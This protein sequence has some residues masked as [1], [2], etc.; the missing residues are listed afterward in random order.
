MGYPEV[1]APRVYEIIVGP[2]RARELDIL[3]YNSCRLGYPPERTS[4]PTWSQII[5]SFGQLAPGHLLAVG[6]K[7]MDRLAAMYFLYWSL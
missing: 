6:G 1:P 3:A 5:W 7:A 2:N 4:L